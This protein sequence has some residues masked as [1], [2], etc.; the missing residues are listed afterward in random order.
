MNKFG[1]YTNFNGGPGEHNLQDIVKHKAQN[2]NRQAAKF[3]SQIA[4][5]NFE[6]D[7]YVHTSV[8]LPHGSQVMHDMVKAC[9]QDLNGNP[10]GRQPDN[11][12]LDMHLWN[13]EFPDGEVTLLTANIIAQAMYAQCNVDRNEYLLIEFFV[14][15]Q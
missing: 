14:E 3:T 12:I 7:E 11:L 13:I 6:C 8:M 2:T 9:K 10:I 4:T 1:S 15:I 5:R